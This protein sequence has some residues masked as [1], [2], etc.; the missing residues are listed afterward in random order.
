MK[1][2]QNQYIDLCEGKMS[3]FNFMRNVRMALPQYISNV[4]SFDDSIKIL[5]NKGIL[6][7]V[8][9]GT[10][11]GKKEYAK[12]SQVENDNLQEF[13]TGINIEHDEAPDKSYDEIEKIVLKNLKKDCHY[14]TLYKLTGIRDYDIQTMDTS[15]PEDHQ[16]KYYDGKN[17]TDKARGMKPVKGFENAKASANKATKETV[18]GETTDLFTLI[19]KTVR[20]LVKMDATGEKGKKI[21]MKEG[22]NI[23]WDTISEKDANSLFDY[24]ERTGK[25]PYDLTPEKY[26]EICAKYNNGHN[27]TNSD[28]SIEEMYF[29]DLKA[30]EKYQKKT[31]TK[32]NIVQATN[33]EGDTF[34]KNDQAKAVD[35]GTVIKIYSF[36]EEQ[37]KIKAQYLVHNTMYTIDIDGLKPVIGQS[38][39]AKALTKEDIEEIVKEIFD[40]R[41]NM[42]DVTGE[43]N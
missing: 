35:N 38:P 22:Q 21:S 14:Y 40:G 29:Q 6:S 32:G 4:V 25:L 16:M 33:D 2:I 23:N 41:D 27:N 1:S 19:A 10:D 26:D 31:D 24:H 28:D 5:K 42:T 7:E 8:K 20:G 39:I 9:E 15:K 18:K 3:Q 17:G 13:T 36:V 34:S 11:S 30:D 43:N 12:F 37:G